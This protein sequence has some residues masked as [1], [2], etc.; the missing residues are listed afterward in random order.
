MTVIIFFSDPLV[1][2]NHQLSQLGLD[3]TDNNPPSKDQHTTKSSFLPQVSSDTNPPSLTASH[4]H[5]KPAATSRKPVQG[6]FTLLM[7]N[8]YPAC[9]A[10][11]K[12][13]IYIVHY[14]VHRLLWLF[15]CVLVL[16]YR[17]VCLY[18]VCVLPPS[19]DQWSPPIS[20]WSH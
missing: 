1:N 8:S 3:Q 2:L 14:K 12:V 11:L 5:S 13:Y 16:L 9:C 20:R 7:H 15:Y 18:S 19:P 17:Y 10:Y 6:N 4:A